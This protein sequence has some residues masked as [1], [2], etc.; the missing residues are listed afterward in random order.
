MWACAHRD[1]IHFGAALAVLIDPPLHVSL[2]CVCGSGGRVTPK[3]SLA[4]TA[5][6]FGLGFSIQFFAQLHMIFASAVLGGICLTFAIV[7][8]PP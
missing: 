8:F 5:I 7:R 6:V 1:V 4:A 2:R 3:L